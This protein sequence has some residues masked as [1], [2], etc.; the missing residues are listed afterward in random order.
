MVKNS[1][2]CLC[3]IADNTCTSQR[4]DSIYYKQIVRCSSHKLN[5]EVHNMLDSYDDLCNT[6]DNVHETVRAEMQLKNAT[7][8][9]NIT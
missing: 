9:R 5:L 1:I 3:L 4:V 7:L 8:L 2:W 6:I